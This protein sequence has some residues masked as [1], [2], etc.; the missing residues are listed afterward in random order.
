MG[1]SKSWANS[2]KTEFPQ[3]SDQQK[4]EA[5][6]RRGLGR[7]V[8]AQEL[9][10]LTN[11]L[12]ST[13]KLAA[14]KQQQFAE[15]SKRRE[16]LNAQLNSILEPVRKQLLAAAGSQ[17]VA[18]DS[19]SVF[20]RWDFSKGLKDSQKGSKLALKS[21]AKIEDGA[22]VLDGQGFCSKRTNSGKKIQEKTL[23]AWVQLDGL[24]QSGGGVITLQ[25]LDGSPIL[26]RLFFAE[27]SERQWLAGSDN[28]R[29]TLPFDGAQEQSD[30]AGPIHLAIYIC[31]R[32]YDYWITGMESPMG[33]QSKKQGRW[34]S[35]RIVPELRLGFDMGIRRPGGRML[36]GR[37]F[38]VRL[39]NRALSKDEIAASFAGQPVVSQADVIAQLSDRDKDRF[40]SLK[41]SI[42]KKQV[43][44]FKA[45]KKQRQLWS[46]WPGL[47]MPF[48]T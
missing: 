39:H 3:A 41:N 2:M 43:S 18:S 10:V 15:L 7:P 17:S 26:I 25:D 23:E 44:R 8:E 11:Y 12:E 32:R 33:I 16:Q 9:E 19:S 29:R 13:R 45:S 30:G 46:Q 42:E 6:F 22:L 48:L 31:G 1:L 36:R 27:L 20:Y 14:S 28:H 34:F 5:M 24:G 37:V 40:F 47:P 35:M 38:D 21:G 4:I